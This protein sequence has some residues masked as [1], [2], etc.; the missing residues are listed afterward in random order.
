M[1]PPTPQF[2]IYTHPSPHTLLPH[3]LPL[4]PCPLPLL[5][6]LQSPLQT[7]HAH[8][9]STI[10]PSSPSLPPLFATAYLDRSRAPETECWLFSSLELPS[11]SSPSSH[12]SPLLPLLAHIA[13]LPLPASYPAAQTP[14]LLLVG[15]LH[16]RVLELLK[17]APVAAG[18]GRKVISGPGAEREERE[19]HIHGSTS[20]GGSNAR[21]VVRGHTVPYTKF[22]FRPGVFRSEDEEAPAGLRW[23]AVREGELPLVLARSEIPRQ[24]RTMRLLRSVGLREG[25]GGEEGRLVAWAFRGLDGSLTSLFVE[26]GWR[27]RGL[28]KMVTRRLLG[29]E[30]WGHSDVA[31][32]NGESVGVARG[33]GG[34]EGWEC[35]WAWVDLGK[36]VE[37]G[38]LE[39]GEGARMG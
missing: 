38:R 15:A 10:P 12:L 14:S 8:I 26:E 25:E 35:F 27:G 37:G 9:L 6:R 24:A 30:E 18:E 23:T 16:R 3:L 34:E 2:Q 28:G 21:G 1:S 7:P 17:G 20:A 11:P 5:L 29:G 32:D 39:G 4:L 13:A 36:V 33:L 19:A 31:K 22:L